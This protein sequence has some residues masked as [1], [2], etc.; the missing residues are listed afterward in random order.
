MILLLDMIINKKFEEPYT[1]FAPDGPIPVL[2]KTLVKSRLSTKFW[3]S[4]QKIYDEI[5]Q[6]NDI[7]NYDINNLN[8]NNESDNNI[9]KYQIEPQIQFEDNIKQNKLKSIKKNINDSNFEINQK[10]NNEIKQ[11]KKVI[12]NLENQIKKKDNIIQNQNND[13]IKIIKKIEELEGMLSQ[14]LSME[15]NS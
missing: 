3:K 15:K 10:L 4:T 14:F 12:S 2:S 1:K 5:N 9:K 7:E 6:E 8:I 11:L 13:K